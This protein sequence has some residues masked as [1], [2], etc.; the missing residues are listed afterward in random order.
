MM[1]ILNVTKI[2]ILLGVYQI[3][4]QEEVSERTEY[5]QPTFKQSTDVKNTIIIA[6]T[7]VL[8]FA[9]LAVLIL[10]MALCCRRNSCRL[11]KMKLVQELEDVELAEIIS[12]QQLESEN[13]ADE[14][15]IECVAQAKSDADPQE[16]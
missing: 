1:G 4:A 5:D 9:V 7:C 12:T 3:Y 16:H 14:T 11:N 13:N 10:T 15:L 6:L 2:L 8:G